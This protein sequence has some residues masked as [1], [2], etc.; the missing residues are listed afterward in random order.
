MGGPE[1]EER[2]APGRPPE[3]RD[4]TQLSD[5]PKAMNSP[6]QPHTTIQNRSKLSK[7]RIGGTQEGEERN[8]CKGWKMT[9][10]GGGGEEGGN[11]KPMDGFMKLSSP[12]HEATKESQVLLQQT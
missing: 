2:P 12:E 5:T 1:K 10:E 9:G 4:Q 11:N 8:G 7:E 6:N 3:D